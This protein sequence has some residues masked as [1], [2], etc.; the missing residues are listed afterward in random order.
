MANKESLS[1][2]S[3]HNIPIGCT[4]RFTN[5]GTLS[6][7]LFP[8]MATL[9]LLGCSTNGDTLSTGL[10]PLFV[11]LYLLSYAPSLVCWH[12]IYLPLL[13]IGDTLSTALFP[14]LVWWYSI[15]R[16]IPL[17]G[18]TLCTGL[19]LPMVTLYIQGCYPNG[20]TLYTGLFPQWWHSIYRAVPPMVTLY[21]LGCSPQWQ[22][23]I[24]RVVL[25]NG[26]T[27][28]FN[29][30]FYSLPMGMSHLR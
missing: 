15:Y 5:G 19:F 22:H 27:E 1:F 29:M 3:S 24:Y 11:T 16:A 8:S 10:F 30:E 4:V 2:A 14:S 21:V 12:S 13:L 25:L 17:I 18:E 26:N 23:S 28:L 7:G 20:D 9:Y 6:T